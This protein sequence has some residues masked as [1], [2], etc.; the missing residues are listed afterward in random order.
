MIREYCNSGDIILDIDADDE[1]I[2]R[3]VFKLVNALYQKGMKGT[4]PIATS[5][6]DEIWLLY[7][8][9]IS[10]DFDLK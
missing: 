6:N 5:S 3:Q 7:L 4:G 9:N 8:N 1:L 2:G 10:F